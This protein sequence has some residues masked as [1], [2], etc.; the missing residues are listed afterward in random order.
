MLDIIAK[1]RS[2]RGYTNEPIERAKID[3]I[4]EAGLHAPSGINRQTPVIIEISDKETRDRLMDLNRR[5]GGWPEGFDPFYGAPTVLMVVAR[6]NGLPVQDGSVTLENML[7]EATNQGLGSC[8]IHRADEEIQS[9][10][11]RE[12]LSFTGLDFNEFVGVGHAII[13]Y[14]APNATYRDKTI[15]EGRVFR[16]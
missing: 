8:W 1:R 7:L 6:K 10:E 12:I 15:L 3:E 11:G 2:C 14:M 16:K 9:A 5:I 4:I 13:G